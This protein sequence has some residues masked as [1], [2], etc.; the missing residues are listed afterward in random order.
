MKE[1]GGSFYDPSNPP[2]PKRLQNFRDVISERALD[3]DEVDE[4][5][6]MGRYGTGFW[7]DAQVYEDSQ[8][9]SSS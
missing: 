6:T 7:S 4:A 5:P 3:E 1:L 9:H 2:D 8:A